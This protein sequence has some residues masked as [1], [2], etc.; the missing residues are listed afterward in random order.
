MP[1]F[2]VKIVNFETI[3]GLQWYKIQSLNGYSRT[4]VK[5][6]LLRRRTGVH[7][8]ISNRRKSRRLNAKEVFTSKK[9]EF[10]HFLLAD[11]TVKLS[12]RDQFITLS[13]E[14]NGVCRMKNHSPI[15]LNTLTLSGGRIRHWM[16]CWKAVLTIIGT[17]VVAGI[18]RNHGPVSRSS[19]Y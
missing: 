6:K 9:V 2:P 18:Y 4:R 10:F 19:Q 11:G 13:Q 1:K 5:Q 12:G 15:P 16:R 17:L 8:S 7:E 14:L 3:N